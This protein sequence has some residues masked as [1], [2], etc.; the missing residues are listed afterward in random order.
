VGTKFR[1]VTVSVNVP[2]PA[3]VDVGERLEFVGTGLLIV[4][5]NA[6]VEGTPPVSTVTW[7]MPATAMSVAGMAARRRVVE[8]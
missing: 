5:G 3:S 6:L 8:T 1:P 4:S 7:A 2:P